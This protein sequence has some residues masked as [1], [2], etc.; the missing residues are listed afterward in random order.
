MIRTH[1][2]V[3]CMHCS[4]LSV[5]SKVHVCN[6]VPLTE[7]AEEKCLMLTSTQRT[8][9]QPLLLTFLD[10]VKT[11]KFKETSKDVP[12]IPIKIVQ[13]EVLS[14]ALA[15]NCDTNPANMRC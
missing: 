9:G 12:V 5:T 6:M 1:S 14:V 10:N 7:R 2:V 11:C 3:H 13:F 8:G 15:K 4:G